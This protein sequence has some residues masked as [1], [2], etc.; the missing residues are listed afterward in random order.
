MAVYKRGLIW[1]FDYTVRGERR[2]GSTG[3]KKKADAEAFV[4]RERRALIMGEAPAQRVWTLRE[5]ADRYFEARVADKKSATTA[6]QRIRI[7]F[8][9][10]DPDTPVNLIGPQMVQ[11]AV[12][13]RRAEKTR[14]GKLP[15]PGTVNRDLIDTTLRP[16]LA[17]AEEMENPV[18]KIIWT[19]YRLKEP[20]G[21]NRVFT[22]AEMAA[23]RD[24][25]PEW[26]RPIFDFLARYG[27]RLDEAFFPP[28]DVNVEEGEVTFRDTKNGRDHT[29]PLLDEDRKAL[30]A[31]KGRAV[32][33]GLPTIWFRE[34]EG[35]LAPIHWRAFQSA[36]KEA[37][38]AAGI[39][40]A[41]PAHD[42]RHHAA[43]IL[44]RETGNLKLV[45]ELLNHKSI[46][47]SARYAHAN[48]SDLKAGLRHTHGTKTGA[49]RGKR[50]RIKTSDGEKSVT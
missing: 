6:A 11:A 23:W 22:D 24:A 31:R 1:H 18:K 7:M 19:K 36:S 16:I 9:H 45:Q 33:A 34:V 43:T 26:H 5:A 17:F 3:L 21:R 12:L 40:D 32:A 38:D 41:K 20:D 35:E 4:E 42:L 8:R 14:Q 15:A 46:T 30:A 10:I 39:M 2:R 48:K 13:A 27:A 47:S 28:A 37:L 50:S 25:L 44:L 49:K 29:I